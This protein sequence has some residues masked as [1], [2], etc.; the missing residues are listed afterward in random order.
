MNGCD[1]PNCHLDATRTVNGKRLCFGHSLEYDAFLVYHGWAVQYGAAQIMR[2]I[3]EAEE[4]VRKI[5][6][7][8]TG[9]SSVRIVTSDPDDPLIVMVF[10]SSEG[11]VGLGGRE[12]AVEMHG[13]ELRRVIDAIPAQ[14]IGGIE[15]LEALQR[16]ASRMG[17]GSDASAEEPGS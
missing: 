10:S 2:D 16:I 6:L 1:Y 17:G 13:P 4:D 7:T 11:P 12:V 9:L 8:I 5:P 14:Y 15:E 3:E